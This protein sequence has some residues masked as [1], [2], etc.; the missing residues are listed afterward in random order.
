[1]YSSLETTAPATLE[2][3]ETS[4][5][6]LPM[7]G[8][9]KLLLKGLKFYGFHGAIA[10]ERTL[11]QMF[12]I[13]ID[14]WVSLKKA[15]LSDNLAD[16]ISYVDIFS[17]AKEIVEGPPLNLLEA[18][19]ERIASRTLEK[20]PRVTAVQVKLVKPN[21]ALIKS[22]IDYLGVEIFRQQKH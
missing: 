21:V 18:V 6:E 4:E 8:G 3:Q 11:G 22:S 17:I 2:P 7:T 10:E 19:A 9:D 1:M 13:D 20:F 5:K 14:A 12:L 16:T 15:G